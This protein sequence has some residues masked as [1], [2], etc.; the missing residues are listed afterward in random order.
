MQKGGGVFR[1]E[2][3]SVG[4]LF[5][6][7]FLCVQEGVCRGSQTGLGREGTECE[8]RGEG[9]LCVAGCSDVFERG[10]VFECRCLWA[11]VVYSSTHL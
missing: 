4:R 2:R 1:S 8:E 3:R 10:Y 5:L 11:E 7:M 9:G 6:Y